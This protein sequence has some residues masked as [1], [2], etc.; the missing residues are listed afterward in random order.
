ML[1]HNAPKLSVLSAPV[2]AAFYSADTPVHSC[3]HAFVGGVSVFITV[4]RTLVYMK[5]FSL[6]VYVENRA[7]K[8]IEILLNILSVCQVH[9]SNQNVVEGLVFSFCLQTISCQ[10]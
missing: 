2:Y 4:L 5:S 9:Y 1:L 10:M 6:N 8:L 7:E 3:P